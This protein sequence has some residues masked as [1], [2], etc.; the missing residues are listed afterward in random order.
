MTDKQVSAIVDRVVARL[1]ARDHD[2]PRVHGTILPCTDEGVAIG[3]AVML[4]SDAQ[5][6]LIIVPNFA[7][8][9]RIR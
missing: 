4:L 5:E 1:L 2:M 8:D 9:R 7:A 3:D 6:A